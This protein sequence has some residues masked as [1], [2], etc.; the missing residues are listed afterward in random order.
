ML[1]LPS[2]AAFVLLREFAKNP[3]K[4]EPSLEP[5]AIVIHRRLE[6]VP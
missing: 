2:Q 3:S 4:T 1:G 6:A 5:Y